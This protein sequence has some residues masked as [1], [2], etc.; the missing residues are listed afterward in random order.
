[1]VLWNIGSG[2][3]E[4]DLE[5]NF[6]CEY[7]AANETLTVLVVDKVRDKDTRAVQVFDRANPATIHR[8]KRSTESGIWVHDTNETAVADYPLTT[9]DTISVRNVTEDS[10]VRVVWIGQDG[11]QIVH[12]SVNGDPANECNSE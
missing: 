5:R 6:E 4:S 10:M 2:F 12:L 1:M 8:G 9:G 7:D 3:N 11:D